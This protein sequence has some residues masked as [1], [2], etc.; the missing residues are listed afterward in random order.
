MRVEVLYFDGCPNYGPAVERLQAVL[1]EEGL[2]LEAEFIE[3]KDEATAKELGFLGSPTIRVNGMDVDTSSRETAET[4]LACRRYPGGLP[5]EEMIRAALR[6]AQKKKG[7]EEMNGHDP[8]ASVQ[9]GDANRD[10]GRHTA[11]VSMAAVG[12]VLAASSCCLPVLPFVAAAGLAGGSTFLSA[13]RPYLLGL[14]VVL[15]GF[16]FY[17]ALRAKKCKQRPSLIGAV[18]LWMSAGF[19]FISIFFPQAMANV[20]ADLLTR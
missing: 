11:L 2:H 4:G 1:R 10:H 19:V 17:Q 7:P 20:T 13:A 15:I 12:S 14:S 18:L 6:E 8:T 9:D 16:G 3:V 5:S